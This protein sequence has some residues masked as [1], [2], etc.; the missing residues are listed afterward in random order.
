MPRAAAAASAGRWREAE[1]CAL[2][3]F[4]RKTSVALSA[5][6]A[7]QFVANMQTQDSF[8]LFLRHVY[9]PKLPCAEIL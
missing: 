3:V 6:T 5:K 1:L 9:S 2:N 8:R 4:L 7:A